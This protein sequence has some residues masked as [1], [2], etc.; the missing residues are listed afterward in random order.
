[1]LRAAASGPCRLACVVRL[2]AGPP[3]A[4]RGPPRR[5]PRSCFLSV[6]APVRRP[7]WAGWAALGHG[8]RARARGQG[9]PGSGSPASV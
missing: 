7:C 5:C 2:L 3:F 4:T 6:P 9:W 1:M 8:P